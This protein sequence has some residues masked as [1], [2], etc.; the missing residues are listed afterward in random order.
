MSKFDFKPASFVR[1]RTKGSIR[2]CVLIL[3]LFVCSSFLAN[4][5][6]FGII[7]DQSAGFG[8]QEESNFDYTA[9]IIPRYTTL[10]GDNGEL[11]ISAGFSYEYINNNSAFIPELLRTE[12]NRLFDFGNLSAGRIYY[13][14]PLGF[15]AN[16]LFDGARISIFSETGKYSIGVWYTGFLYKKRANIAMNE[17]E[18]DSFAL[19]LDFN[20]FAG[21][22]FAPKRLIGALDWEHLSLGPFQARASIIGQFDLDGSL[23]SQYIACR[24][25]WPANS[26]SINLGGCLELIQDNNIFGIAL[27]GEA[28]F[29]MPLPTQA[30]D[31]L[32]LYG[33]F[34]SAVFEESLMRAFLPITTKSMGEIFNAKF[35][36]VSCIALNYS[37]VLNK[38]LSLGLNSSYFILSDTETFS[39]YPLLD[40]R[41]GYFLGNEF[42]GTVS[43]NPFS[44]LQINFKGGAFLP[45]LGNAAP[46]AG[47]LWRLELNVVFG[48]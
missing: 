21:T 14:D 13:S 10:L 30:Q 42:Y 45:S 16:G 12:L 39:G 41:D 47:V 24:I 33:R 2:L 20:N 38:S 36:G 43:W 44:D 32:S 34:S 8:A 7:I 9:L 35:S 15:I 3:F 22:Y 48:L 46:N 11:Y 37:V 25:T 6:D 5:N 28:G 19:D 23:H 31:K 4:A 40:G 17:E 29:S 26:F 18:I 1:L 27:A